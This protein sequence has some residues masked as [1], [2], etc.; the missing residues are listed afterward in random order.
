MD[1]QINGIVAN[2]RR[3]NPETLTP[4]ARAF[5]R[6]I[7]AIL[8][9]KKSINTNI[10]KLVARTIIRFHYDKG[11]SI[12]PLIVEMATVGMFVISPLWRYIPQMVSYFLIGIVYGCFSITENHEEI[13]T[14]V[15]QAIMAFYTN[16]I[17]EFG[18]KERRR[19][20]EAVFRL[21]GYL[22]QAN[23]F[24]ED[25]RKI[26]FLKTT[27]RQSLEDG[28]AVC[29]AGAEETKYLNSSLGS[30][31]RFIGQLLFFKNF[32]WPLLDLSSEKVLQTIKAKTKIS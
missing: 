20:A 1:N 12:N 9:E 8:K 7:R 5:L 3:I 15:A 27:L 14:S 11:E 28:F 21:E 23:T 6:N 18:V 2:V 13:Q 32:C 31:Q 26:K 24:S 22:M 19:A 29:E 16:P 17:Y 25:S 4:E 10:S 30:Y